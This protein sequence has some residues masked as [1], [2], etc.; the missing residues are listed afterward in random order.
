MYDL[1]GLLRAFIALDS[2]RG[3]PFKPQLF[4][5]Y[6]VRLELVNQWF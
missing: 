6:S 2:L 4:V 1:G 3:F 5:G